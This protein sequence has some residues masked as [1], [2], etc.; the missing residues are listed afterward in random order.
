M[1]NTFALPL[2]AG[3]IFACSADAA[4]ELDV[5]ETWLPFALPALEPA[6]PSALWPA[7]T[8]LQQPEHDPAPW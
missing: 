4:F 6:V 8:A 7:R 3:L 1:S 2:V 5:L